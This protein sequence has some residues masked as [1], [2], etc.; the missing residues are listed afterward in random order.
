MPSKPTTDGGIVFAGAQKLSLGEPKPDT[1]GPYG[2]YRPPID[3]SIEPVR[4][5]R[6]QVSKPE[7]IVETPEIQS[8]NQKPIER[9]RRNPELPPTKSS[10][11]YRPSETTEAEPINYEIFSNNNIPLRPSLTEGNELST[12]KSI[13]VQG[14]PKTGQPADFPI[15]PRDKR[16][17]QKQLTSQLVS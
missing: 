13:L 15:P 14:Q 11:L 2:T 5:S 3:P 8:V 9:Q 12:Q 4:I 17:P 16:E 6:K 7:F 1:R 10:R